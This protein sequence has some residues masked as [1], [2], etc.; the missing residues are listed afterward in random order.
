[1]KFIALLI[2]IYFMLG[3]IGGIALSEATLKRPFNV[4][5]PPNPHK[6]E[7]PPF[8]LALEILLL[9]ILLGLP[10]LGYRRARQQGEFLR[11]SPKVW[12]ILPPS[13]VGSGFLAGFLAFRFL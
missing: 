9:A 7:R 11:F 12:L 4:Q 6:P 5:T 10:F 13:L 2:F 3:F 1:M 8:Q